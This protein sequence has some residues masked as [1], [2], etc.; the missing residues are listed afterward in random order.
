MDSSASGMLQDVAEHVEGTFPALLLGNIR[1][2]L[3]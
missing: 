3:D 2:L 1:K